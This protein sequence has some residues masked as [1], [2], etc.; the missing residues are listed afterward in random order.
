MNSERG[1]TQTCAP[2]WLYRDNVC[3]LEDTFAQAAAKA[4][5][6]SDVLRTISPEKK[7]ELI[8]K[9]CPYIE[10]IDI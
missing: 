2:C 1:I 8:E 10:G 5:F 6:P 9:K 4:Q 7:K 3:E